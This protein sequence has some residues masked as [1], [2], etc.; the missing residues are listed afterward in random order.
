MAARLLIDLEEIR[1]NPLPTVSASPVADNLFL[2]H[3]N[4]LGIESSPYAGAIFH[5]EVRSSMYLYLYFRG[6]LRHIEKL[7]HS[8]SH[9]LSLRLS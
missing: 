6:I 7:S 5:L 9:S 2:W 8:H 1:R 3:A 4:L